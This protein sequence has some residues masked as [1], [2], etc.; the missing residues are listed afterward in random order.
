MPVISMFF[1]II[2]MMRFNEHLPPHFHAKYQDYEASFTFDGELL[3][4]RMPPKQR[5]VIAGWAVIHEEDLM[6][7]WELCQARLTPEKIEGVRL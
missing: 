1:G 5:K 4:G 7:D 6:A 3:E 2:I